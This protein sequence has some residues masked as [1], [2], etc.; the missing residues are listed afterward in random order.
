MCGLGDIT[1]LGRGAHLV[2]L[3]FVSISVRTVSSGK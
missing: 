2:F 3:D 1:D